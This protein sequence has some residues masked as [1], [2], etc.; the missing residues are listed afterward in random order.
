MLE[1]KINTAI[2]RIR[3]GERLALK[4][5]ADGICVLFSGGKDS[6][7]VL[8]LTKMAGVKYTADFNNTTIE[9]PENI[10]F[11]KD[12]YPE[13][14]IHQPKLSFVQ[15]CIKNHCLPNRFRRFC[16]KELKETFGTSRLCVTGVRRAE[17]SKRAKR[18]EVT[19]WLGSKVKDEYEAKE[20]EHKCI[21][22]V[23][24]IIVN[25][26][27]DWSDRD[28]WQFIKQ[29]NLPRNPCY[30]FSHRVGCVMCP[31]ATPKKRI[32]ESLRY[33]SYVKMIKYIIDKLKKRGVSR[34]AKY[35]SDALLKS[36]LEDIT[37]DKA[38]NELN[39]PRFL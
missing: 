27:I 32:A 18:A 16:C 4:Y 17:S 29:R 11:I 35:S 39:A 8:E 37:P 12:Y 36:Y 2:E 28:V 31:M 15:M 22:G 38:E 33:P 13:V 26:I 23:D 3:K 24:K 30:E 6:Q 14:T 7:C 1:E 21:N 9:F 20:L 5:S 34:F 19:E 10:R 25:P